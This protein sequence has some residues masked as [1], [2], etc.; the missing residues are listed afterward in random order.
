MSYKKK[1]KN[2]NTVWPVTTV[3][4][5][6]IWHSGVQIKLGISPFIFKLENELKPRRKNVYFA[7]K[8]ETFSINSTQSKIINY[9]IDFSL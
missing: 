8:L 5:N 2:S 7:M 1:K 3:S 6:T 9:L 4:W